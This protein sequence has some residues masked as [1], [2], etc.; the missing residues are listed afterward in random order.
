MQQIRDMGITDESV[1][2]RALEA[3]GGDI[4]AALEIIFGDGGG[5]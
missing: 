5:F 4:Q 2:R 3:S 1:A